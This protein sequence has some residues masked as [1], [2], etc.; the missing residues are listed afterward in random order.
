MLIIIGEVVVSLTL[1]PILLFV[2]R[3]SYRNNVSFKNPHLILENLTFINGDITNISSDVFLQKRDNL[4]TICN[5]SGLIFPNE[6]YPGTLSYF[7]FY[8]SFYADGRTIYRTEIYLK[9][10]FENHE[11]FIREKERLNDI[12]HYEKPSFFSKSL[13]S[14]P[15]YTTEYN[16]EGGFEYALLDETDS[17]IEY[18]YLMGVGD[19]TQIV[20]DEDKIPIKSPNDS[21]FPRNMISE[22]YYSIYISINKFMDVTLVVGKHAFLSR[23]N[24]KD[25]FLFTSLDFSE[26][27]CDIADV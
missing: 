5:N 18:I 7:E 13:F 26:I 1:G 3:S 8:E 27:K 4:K 2:E 6:A 20:F 24:Q 17:V 11:Y 9:W 10:E 21:D 19:K 22:G 16:H 25:N 23:R 15:S 14:L 12:K